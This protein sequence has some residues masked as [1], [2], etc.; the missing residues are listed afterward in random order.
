MAGC[1]RVRYPL[2]CNLTRALT[3]LEQAYFIQVTALL[4]DRVLGPEAYHRFHPVRDSKW[5]TWSR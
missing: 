1:E 2:A 4:E 3:D 5:T